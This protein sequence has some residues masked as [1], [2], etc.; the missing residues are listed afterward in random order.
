M[1]EEPREANEAGA[2]GARSRAAG[3][4]VWRRRQG[5][6]LW[7]SPG[8]RSL[9]F[10]KQRRT[11]REG[12][13]DGVIVSTPW[14]G[15]VCVWGRLKMVMSSSLLFSQV[16]GVYSLFP[17]PLALDLRRPIGSGRRDAVCDF[18]GWALQSVQ[19]PFLPLGTL[20]R[21]TQPPLGEAGVL[22]VG[23]PADSKHQGDDS[24]AQNPPSGAQPTHRPWRDK[25][26]LLL[27]ATKAWGRCVTQHR[28]T[29]T[30]R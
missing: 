9:E 10:I 17:P 21:D 3:D 18:H 24:P 27:E 23:L 11:A 22:R 16:D 4:E 26:E 6:D 7:R 20:P 1:W 8:Q 30:Q 25:W 14:V 28:V 15:C 2:Q 12:Q 19:P 29:V 13:E 5:S